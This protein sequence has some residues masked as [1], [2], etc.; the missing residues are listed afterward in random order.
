[1]KWYK[2]WL[3]ANDNA[4]STIFLNNTSRLYL[5]NCG[6]LSYIPSSQPDPVACFVTV[7]VERLV[8]QVSTMLLR[9]YNHS[10]RNGIGRARVWEPIKKW[11]K[12]NLAERR[13]VCYQRIESDFWSSIR[14]LRLQTKRRLYECS[15]T[16]A[17]MDII[18]IK[19]SST[20]KKNVTLTY[21]LTTTCEQIT[22]MSMEKGFWTTVLSTIRRK[23]SRYEPF[24]SAS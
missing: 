20:S 5:I 10:Y 3:H 12:Q 24:S 17:S 8:F 23:T 9:A 15:C 18:W 14:D 21:T 1:M 22:D 6:C 2:S 4:A 16:V 11:R 19:K 13:L 7:P